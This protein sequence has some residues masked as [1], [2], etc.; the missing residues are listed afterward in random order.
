MQWEETFVLRFV[1]F[2]ERKETEDEG[3]KK[4]MRISHQS[5]NNCTVAS[6]R[7]VRREPGAFV[8]SMRPIVGVKLCIYF[9]I[10]P[11]PV[12]LA[13]QMQR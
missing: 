11:E 1:T 13:W 7:V 9:S 6:H 5:G 3:K 8:S 10:M 12:P 4:R 2:H